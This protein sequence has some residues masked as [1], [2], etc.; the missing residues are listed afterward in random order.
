MLSIACAAYW[1]FLAAL[2]AVHLSSQLWDIRVGRTNALFYAAL[3]GLGL[4]GALI[5]SWWRRPERSWSLLGAAGLVAWLPLFRWM[6]QI[7]LDAQHAGQFILWPATVAAAGLAVVHL[8]SVPAIRDKLERHALAWLA[9]IVLWWPV[10]LYDLPPKPLDIHRI[11]LCI[12]PALYKYG[13]GLV[14]TIDIFSQYGAGQGF[15]FAF[16]L[17]D[18]GQATLR[19]FHV[20]FLA[21]CLG[22]FLAAYHL[23]ARLL[24]S[25]AWAFGVCVLALLLQFYLDPSLGEPPDFQFGLSITPSVGVYRIAWLVPVVWLFARL[26]RSAWGLGNAVLLGTVLGLS[27]F[28]STDVGAAL[29][30]ASVGATWLLCRPV[31]RSLSC[32][33]LLAVAA[34]GTFFGVSAAAYGPRVLSWAYLNG[35]FGPWLWYTDEQVLGEPHYAGEMDSGYLF[36]LV[37]LAWAVVVVALLTTRR[38]SAS[39]RR[40]GLVCLALVSL[41]LHAK[42]GVMVNFGYWAGTAL[43]ALAVLAWGFKAIL[44]SLYRR[45]L[46]ASCRRLGFARGRGWPRALAAATAVAFAAWVWNGVES[47]PEHDCHNVYG[48]RAYEPYNSLLNTAIRATFC[49]RRAPEAL[50]PPDVASANDLALIRNNTKP[51]ERAA[52]ISAMDW[53]LL[54]EAQRPPRYYFLPMPTAAAVPFY[55]EE[56]RR[57]TSQAPVVFLDKRIG[58]DVFW[59]F[60]LSLDDFNWVEETENL[61]LYRR[62]SAGAAAPAGPVY[63]PGTRVDFRLTAARPYL[64]SGWY[65]AEPLYRF[66]RREAAVQFRLE[67]VQPLRLQ[68]EANTFG[69]QRIGIRLNGREAATFRGSG[70]PLEVFEADLPRDAIAANNTLEFLL[71]DA[72]SPRSVGEGEDARVLGVGI[73]W[74]ELTPVP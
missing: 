33:G 14:P 7:T 24:R 59:T 21:V 23:L 47:F 65:P 8:S 44:P 6:V 37:A 40:S 11:S 15:F 35:V 16:F 50:P 69:D 71:P 67:Q 30:A 62:S 55:F 32:S 48:F 72:K 58:E 34:V 2:V 70:G 46:A 26:G 4:A 20:L 22:V 10:P 74:M 17:G 60:N 13:R 49:N 57:V 27:A 9:L 5:A 1:G 63:R 64:H 42:Y 36:T 41:F 53:A 39:F 61:L 3:L 51:G 29:A 45:W 28:W 19:H 54:I 52:V 56:L 38:R 73:Q 68:M 18:T 43:P 31:V 12:A 25:R 66:S